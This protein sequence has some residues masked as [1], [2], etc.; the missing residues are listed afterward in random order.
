MCFQSPIAF[1]QS[2]GST[3]A[4]F[5]PHGVKEERL[6]QRM[7]LSDDQA[8]ALNN[9]LKGLG[10]VIDT[11]VTYTLQFYQGVTKNQ[12]SKKFPMWEITL[13]FNYLAFYHKVVK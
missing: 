6:I 5:R 12:S 4:S 10:E 11:F 13:D 3:K 1:S 8:P 7:T 2:K 9:S